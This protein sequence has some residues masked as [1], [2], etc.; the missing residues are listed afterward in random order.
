[1]ERIREEAAGWLIRQQDDAMDWEGFTAWLEA[2]PQHRAAYDELALLEVDL[3]AHA[4]MVAEYL[5]T[6]QPLPEPANDVQ[7]IRWKRWAGVGGGVAAAM[8]VVGLTLQPGGPVDAVQ[9]YQSS[10]AKSS[11][12]ALA[13]GTRVVLAPASRLRVRGSELDL[14]GTGYF[15]VPHRSGRKL[16][17]QAG[18]IAV[19][20]I[21]TK[22]SIG[23]EP[24]G[25]IVDV[26]EGSLSVTSR[27]LASPIQLKA[28]RGIRVD[29]S[30]GT[31]RLA[32]I[33]PSHVASWRTGKLQFDQVP[34]SLVVKDISRYSGQR[35]T[36]AQAIASQPF[37]GVI[38][39]N[40]GQSPAQTLAQILSLEAKPVAGGIRLEPRRR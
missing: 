27:R 9:D 5:P 6:A 3:D 24:E 37:S 30:N 28:G 21:G 16:T 20:D 4:P 23:N 26:A 31:V 8:L 35:V 12:I 7:P 1:M 33:D 10:N 29:R 19:T 38:A 25:A 17:I 2:D 13:D 22:F 40:D 14:Q 11:Q 39:I 15:E 32:D 18:D 34:L 36:V